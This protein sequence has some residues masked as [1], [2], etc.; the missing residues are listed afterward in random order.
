M[1]CFHEKSWPVAAFPDRAQP[2][3]RDELP[4][5]PTGA[6]VLIVVAAVLLL[7]ADFS[8][9]LVGLELLLVPVLVLMARGRIRARLGKRE[10]AAKFAER[11]YA[12]AGSGRAGADIRH[13]SGCTRV[14]VR[15]KDTDSPADYSSPTDAD[16]WAAWARLGGAELAPAPRPVEQGPEK[17]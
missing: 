3:R 14:L 16:G 9:K 15:D 5:V 10:R 8:W 1:N 17:P 12:P 2:L 4:A 7:V 6:P 11:A 13:C